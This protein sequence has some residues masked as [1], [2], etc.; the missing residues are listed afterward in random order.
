MRR[1]C[2]RG[3]F[4]EVIFCGTASGGNSFNPDRANASVFVEAGERVLLDCGS[5]SLERLVRA[6]RSINEISAVF[7]SHLHH[8]HVLAL[9]EILMRR[10]F[11][12]SGGPIPIFGPAGTAEFMT[13]VNHLVELLAGTRPTVSFQG[14]EVHEAAPVESIV[15]GE[16]T[17]S[18]VEV[19]H[20]PNLQCFGWK[21]T[22]GESSVVYSGD[23]SAIP[24]VM[25]PFA[26]DADLLIHD[27]YTEEALT[28]LLEQLP[29]ERREIAEQVVPTTHSDVRDVGPIAQAAGVKQLA[30][31]AIFPTENPGRLEMLAAEGFSGPVVATH[32]GLVIRI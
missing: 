17:A 30:L 10:S 29:P 25:V 4:V 27:A 28:R 7:L 13:R 6:G 16:L 31:T 8:D 32:D 15:L 18:C 14:G 26:R 21:L 22:D 3:A 19:A 12:G 1:A 11:R 24:T 9:P 20:A 2:G 23:T 5:G